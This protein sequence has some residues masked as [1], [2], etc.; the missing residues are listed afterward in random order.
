MLDGYAD[1]DFGTGIAGL[2]LGDADGG[3]IDFVEEV[4]A[5]VD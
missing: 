1:E 5:F 3:F 2:G 4:D